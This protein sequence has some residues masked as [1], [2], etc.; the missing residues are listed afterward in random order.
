MRVLKQMME[1]QERV[2]TEK[3][4]LDEKLGKL[5]SFITTGVFA[6]LDVEEQARLFVQ[7]SVMQMYSEVL[8]DRIEA[9]KDDLK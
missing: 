1:Y 9:F 2:I 7:R 4:E 8:A 3:K 6:A 5:T